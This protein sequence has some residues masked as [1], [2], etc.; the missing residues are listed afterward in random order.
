VQGFEES[1]LDVFTIFKKSFPEGI[2]NPKPTVPIIG[3]IVL[4]VTGVACT[5]FNL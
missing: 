3:V 2:F 5:L 1:L 4:D